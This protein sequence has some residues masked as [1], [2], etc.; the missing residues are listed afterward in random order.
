MKKLL[1]FLL[2]I[3]F[4]TSCEDDI[5][6]DERMK[7]LKEIEENRFPPAVIEGA[8]ETINYRYNDKIYYHDVIFYDLG[9]KGAVMLH[10]PECKY[11]K[12]GQ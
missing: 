8:R 9:N 11:C 12:Q 5:R 4:F 2:V 7:F 10:L 1:L 6:R 3:L